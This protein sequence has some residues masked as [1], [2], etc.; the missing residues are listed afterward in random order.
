MKGLTG[1]KPLNPS[2]PIHRFFN[3]IGESPPQPPVGGGGTV[4]KGMSAL[5]ALVRFWRDDA[6]TTAIEYGL[7]ALFISV[8]I[9]VSVNALGS[10]VEGLF[11]NVSSQLATAGR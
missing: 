2:H 7:I 9:V 1:Q 5:R 6:A 3:P 11:T 4:E 8:A 10:S